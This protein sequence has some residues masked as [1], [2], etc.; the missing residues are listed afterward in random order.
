MISKAKATCPNGH[1]VEFGPCNTEKTV[2]FLFK[3][4]CTS[5]DHEVISRDEIQC[6]KCH[7]IHMARPCS[8]CGEHV[9]VAKFKQ[10]SMMERLKR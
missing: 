9:P 10:K 8:T 3:S 5:K 4:V 2:F 7:T 1:I 6:Q